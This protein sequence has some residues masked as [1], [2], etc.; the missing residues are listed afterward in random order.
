MRIKQLLSNIR[1]AFKA[2]SLKQKEAYGRF[3]H[4]LS[5]ASFIGCA[6]L[7]FA[8]S[9]MDTFTI[10]KVI[11]LTSWGVIAF[12]VAALLSKGE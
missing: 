2:P 12:I 5:A 6:T 11:A 3:F 1:V 4:T 10:T 8:G 7:L 9:S